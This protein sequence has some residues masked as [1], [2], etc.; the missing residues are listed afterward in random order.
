MDRREKIAEMLAARSV[1]REGSLSFSCPKVECCVKAGQ[2]VEGSFCM[3]GREDTVLTG[4]VV[5]GDLR[6]HCLKSE[7]TGNPS[8]VFYRFDST[9][10]E[11]REVCTGEF[12][13]VSNQGEYTLPYAITV[14]P[15]LFE[16]SLGPMKNLFHF[17][18]LAKTNWREA[19][20]VFY[21]PGFETVLSG[22]DRQYLNGY[23][24]L[25]ALPRQEQKVEEFLIWVR[26]KQPVAY[27]CDRDSVVISA[28]EDMIREV[29]TL[30]RDGWGHTRLL[31][32]T[33]GRFLQAEKDV[34]TDDD[35]LG[36][37]CHCGLIIFRDALHGGRN[38]GKVRFFNE[39]VSLEIAVCAEHKKRTPVRRRKGKRRKLLEFYQQ[40]LQYSV[41]RLSKQEWLA[42]TEAIVSGMNYYGKENPVK[43]LFQAQLQLTK[44]RYKEAKW[45][46][47]YAGNVIV[48][49]ETRPE[50]VCYYLYLTTLTSK[51]GH[52]IRAV[53]E[54]IRRIY[55]TD[56]TNW[57]VAWLLLYLDEECGKS[58]SRKWLFLEQQFERGCR[59]PI[60][61]MEAAMLVRKNPALLMKTT[62]FVMQT[63]NF[64]AKYDFL[65]DACIGQVHYLADRLK[66]Y[67]E[68]MYA[69]LQVCYEKKK[70][71]ETLRAICT[72]LIKGNKIGPAYAV[73]YRKGIE[74]E[75]WITRLYEHYIL[76]V[77]LQKKES[78]PAAALRYFS[79]RSELPY[80]RMAYLYAY[81]MRRRDK[82]PDLYRA[83][84][85]DM[86]RFLTEQLEKRRMNQDIAFV[87]H[88][89][90]QEGMVSEELLGRY[91]D[92]L[93]YHEIRVEAS[94]I[95]RV[96]VVYGKLR[97][98]TIWP[99]SDGVAYVPLYDRDFCLIFEK[100]S[101][102]RFI[103]EIPYE[104]QTLFYPEEMLS[105]IIPDNA[106][107]FVEEVGVALYQCEHGKSYT[108]VDK[109]NVRYAQRLWSSGQIREAYRD[110]LGMKLLQYFYQQDQPEEMDQ[111]LTGLHPNRMNARERSETV[112]YLL[113]RGL[114]DTAYEWIVRYG[115]EK[116]KPKV[117]AR[118]CSR[119]LPRY[120]YMEAENLT[121][122]A[123][124][125]FQRGKY[126]EDILCYL[127]RYFRGTVRELWELWYAC[128]QFDTGSYELC[129]R[130]L[131][132]MLFAG[133]YIAEE[134]EV[135]RKYLEGSADEKL[136][137]AC[138]AHF[139]W[140]Y[141]MY[142]QELA[143]FI[144]RE[145]TRKSRNGEQQDEICELALLKYFA[146]KS[147]LEDEERQMV[148]EFMDDLILK[149]GIVFPFFRK[150]ADMIPAMDCYMDKT[151]LEYRSETENPVILHYMR[152]SRDKS[153][154]YRMEEL[155]N[156]YAGI[157][158]RSFQ[159]FAGEVVQYYI[160]EKKGE[161]EKLVESGTLGGDGEA[162]R[163]E[164]GRFG[165]INH[166]IDDALHG[167]EEKARKILGQYYE[168][169][170]SAG[171]L[172]TLL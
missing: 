24:A 115:A 29:I 168:T 135:Y 153:G 5:T 72:L 134:A 61:Y 151:F 9:G 108:V 42:S 145:L 95:C 70:D 68:R 11:E 16:T 119:L 139:A 44:E 45:L 161:K 60:W 99:V 159:L 124:M 63:L 76:S 47:D 128:D 55:Q 129:E 21:S 26:K 8:E 127:S 126:D 25:S 34:L 10:L 39:Y 155:K 48:P 74:C 22:N 141:F 105:D 157:Y 158:V 142:D 156:C 17:A 132:Q 57:Q 36:D 41:G 97:N 102:S 81:V 149:R 31:V 64:M 82:Y 146:G 77:D 111:Y 62:P 162:D 109:G 89:M 164:V 148:Q 123:H 101:G 172:F 88:E 91:A 80:E 154:E 169:E 98:E 163:S 120:D 67:S 27:T 13:I 131:L 170:F 86:E 166:L 84:F 118:L 50:T 65:T 46:L 94:D 33:K 32:E 78:I 6:M 38:Y 2:S 66:Q 167:R 137:D 56:P 54:E 147:G 23:R 112:R 52:Y 106:G 85:P 130:L 83:Y 107:L 40:Y 1:C 37:Q 144:W 53:T 18:N 35:F 59:S 3:T 104:D 133:E 92:R 43:E 19:V 165:M 90:I 114:Y 138:L 15:E 69:V 30:T 152:K 4:T 93:F 71:V 100:E 20:E 150:F 75:L 103:Y 140:Q 14:Q 121:I 28:S 160:T 110:E 116:V 136:A 143:P 96:I 12:K 58:V 7:F 117:I 171:K 87:F 73:W 49:E 113:S 79:Y 125:A 122:L 51:D